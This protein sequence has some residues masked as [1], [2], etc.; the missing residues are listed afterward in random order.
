[1]ITNLDVPIYLRTVLKLDVKPVSTDELIGLCPHPDHHDR[2][3]SWYINKYTGLHQCKSCGY[4]GSLKSLSSLLLGR[5]KAESIL[6]KLESHEGHE[7][8]H[9]SSLIDSIRN[10]KNETQEEFDQESYDYYINNYNNEPY[11]SLE[12]VQRI[13]PYITQQVIHD[14]GLKH[15]TLPGAYYNRIAIPIRD[16]SGILNVNFRR[17][18]DNDQFKYTCLPGS[19]SKQKLPSTIFLPATINGNSK[20]PYLL[21]TEGCF[22]AIFLNL[23]GYHACAIYS[24]NISPSQVTQVVKLTSNPILCLDSDTQGLLGQSKSYDYMSNYCLTLQFVYPESNKDPD[25][26]NLSYLNT[27]LNSI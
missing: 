3:P 15:W 27:F 25:E 14:Y 12:L 5:F 10:P 7:Y 2:N 4:K 23:H 19:A 20:L 21:I 18:N 26:W 8:E 17:I 16:S 11:V 1:M 22:D 24:N 6:G 13:K 9:L